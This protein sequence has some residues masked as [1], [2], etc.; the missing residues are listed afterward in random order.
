[1]RR[2]GLSVVE[3]LV[4]S[5]CFCVTVLPLLAM[6]AGNQKAS[7]RR[8]ARMR[9][10][11]LAELVLDCVCAM[12]PPMLHMMSAEV[13][14]PPPPATLLVHAALGDRLSPPARGLP[15]PPHRPGLEGF[16]GPPPGGAPGGPGRELSAT[17]ADQRYRVLVGVEKDVDGVEHLDCVT[18]KLVPEHRRGGAT[19]LELRRVLCVR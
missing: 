1:M 2:R 6:L 7:S 3:V 15:P 11:A 13:A 14:P 4:A 16:G 5:V 9:L 18:V 12:P 10:H 17:V 19:E 8:M